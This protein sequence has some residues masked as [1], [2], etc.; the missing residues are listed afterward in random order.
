MQHDR[1]KPCIRNTRSG[2]EL[3]LVEKILLYF[4]NAQ[5]STLTQPIRIPEISKIASLHHV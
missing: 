2:G 1:R 4:E 5:S 3:Q